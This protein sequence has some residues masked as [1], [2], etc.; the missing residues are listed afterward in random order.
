MLIAASIFCFAS[1]RAPA[2]EV[3]NINLNEGG[4]V[5]GTG[6]QASWLGS[7]Y[8][9]ASITY[10]PIYLVTGG[11]TVN[12]GSLLIYP[13][14]DGHLGLGPIAA[15]LSDVGVSFDPPVVP[16]QPSVWG[17]PPPLP[18]SPNP[19]LGVEFGSCSEID[20]SCDLETGGILPLS[21]SL[22]YV[23]PDDAIAIQ[24][25]WVGDFA[26]TAPTPIP[27]AIVLFASGLGGLG[28]L[29]WRSKTKAI[30]AFLHG[31]P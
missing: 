10:S 19:Y 25:A 2:T 14:L 17:E 7:C 4:G 29:G 20:P 26:Y 13:I 31:S 30:P 21:I 27:S 6:G 3:V 9:A 24:L 12:F 1:V 16:P 22:E 5:P 23:I 18:G 8:C 15:E 11:E 28:L